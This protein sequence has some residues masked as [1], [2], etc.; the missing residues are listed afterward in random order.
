[1]A[2]MSTSSAHIPLRSDV[3]TSTVD[4]EQLTHVFLYNFNLG[5][6]SRQLRAV[7]EGEWWHATR[8]HHRHYSR[9]NIIF[10]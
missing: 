6:P 1:M 10:A 8:I 2:T 3:Q 7:Q 4:F 9:F 5:E